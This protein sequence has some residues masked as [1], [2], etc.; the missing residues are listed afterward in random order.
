MIDTPG[1]VKS[2]QIYSDGKKTNTFRNKTYSVI[3][4]LHVWLS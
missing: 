4:L 1:L 3:Y 2:H